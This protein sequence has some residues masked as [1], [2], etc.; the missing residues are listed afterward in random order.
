MYK[1]SVVV[2][3]HNGEVFLIDCLKSL[4][5]QVDLVPEVI[6]VDDGSTDSS[7]RIIQEYCDSFN[8]FYYFKH[9]RNLG[10]PQALNTGLSHSHGEWSTW[11]SHD[12]Y[13]GKSYFKQ[14]QES[15]E[16]SACDAIYTSYFEVSSEIKVPILRSVEELE[17]RYCGNIF[18]A[19]FAYRTSLAKNLGGFDTTKF[20]YEDYDFMIRVS[21]KGIIR[22]VHSPLDYYYRVHQ[23]QLTNT[24]KLPTQYYEWRLS[25][26][27][28][29]QF[30]DKG[31]IAR[32]SISLLHISVIAK[33]FQV[34]LGCLTWCLRFPSYCARYV[35]DKIKNKG[36]C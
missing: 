10:L 19:S 28:R 26:I 5:S 8:N 22:R 13:V 16:L 17:Y 31:I 1:F 12:N 14:L 35:I 33:K 9:P 27:N 36:I 6:I 21:E 24:K 23:N 18:G 34:V 29:I 4:S 20:L 15:L 11:I 7:S 2:P 32:A 30:E 25:L 3:V